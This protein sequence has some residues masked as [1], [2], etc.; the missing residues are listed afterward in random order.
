[1]QVLHRRRRR[2][3]QHLAQ[4]LADT[5]ARRPGAD[6][7]AN[8]T[9]FLNLPVPAIAGRSLAGDLEHDHLQQLPVPPASSW[10]TTSIAAPG[11]RSA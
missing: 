7:L 8:P 11:A 9:P 1:M 3:D 2:L 6:S 5:P 4:G 10:S